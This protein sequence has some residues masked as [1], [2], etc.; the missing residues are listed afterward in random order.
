[1]KMKILIFTFFIH[2]LFLAG[3]AQAVP[4]GEFTDVKGRVDVT[5]T[6]EEARP[7]NLG[8]K[9]NVGDIVRTKSESTAEIT[10][11]D[12]NIIKLLPAS[13]LEISEYIVDEKQTKGI[14]SLFRGTVRSI[15]KG[16]AFKR[17]GKN[18]YEVHTPTA[19]VGVRGTDF[20]AFFKNGVSGAVFYKNKG[21]CYNINLPDV[22]KLIKQGFGVVVFGPKN[23]PI[24]V[25][26][27]DP[28]LQQFLAG[29]GFFE[30]GGLAG[31]GMPGLDFTSV[32]LSLPTSPRLTHSFRDFAFE[33][34]QSTQGGTTTTKTGRS[35]SG[36]GTSLYNEV[37]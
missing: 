26:A 11:V 5:V 36:G 14:L 31:T 35:I 25:P 34:F 10:L 3:F 27:S 2:F 1:M 8:D 15:V 37:E 13:R 7:V 4:V 19:V 24:I 20:S 17:G 33:T 9:V 6:G 30:S 16:K 29:I 23:A 18:V 12:E 28:L 21:Y 22:I 32:F